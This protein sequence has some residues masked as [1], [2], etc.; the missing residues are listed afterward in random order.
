MDRQ[1]AREAIRLLR[2]GTPKGLR[3]LDR[4][5]PETVRIATDL[6]LGLRNGEL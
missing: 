2:E 4:N 1:H 5:D 6:A 3:K